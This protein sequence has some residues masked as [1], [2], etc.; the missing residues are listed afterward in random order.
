MSVKTRPHC[1][2]E[3]GDARKRSSRLRSG[4]L[5]HVPRLRQIRFVLHATRLR[6]PDSA[7]FA[8]PILMPVAYLIDRK[9][10]TPRQM[11]L[12]FARAFS[13]VANQIFSYPA[14]S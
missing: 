4:F 8:A 2:G 1:A 14:S 13:V 12:F 11:R 7:A 9:I 3:R 5:R 6:W 10:P